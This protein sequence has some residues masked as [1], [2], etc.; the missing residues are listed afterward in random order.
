MTT[1]DTK[2]GASALPFISSLLVLAIGLI[3]S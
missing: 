1:D 3:A 2:W